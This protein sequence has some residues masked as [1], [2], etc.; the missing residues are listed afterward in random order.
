M[1]LVV[2]KKNTRTIPGEAKEPLENDKYEIHKL[3]FEFEIIPPEHWRAMKERWSYLATLQK[4]MA[5]EPDYEMPAADLREAREPIHEIA[6]R[7]L[8]KVGPL[9]DSEG[10]DIEFNDDVKA[11]ILSWPWMHG[12]I[13]DTFLAVQRGMTLTDFLKDRAEQERLEKDRLERERRKN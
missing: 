1:P 7:Y 10:N 5:D 12:P 8:R 6:G 4:R 11:Q 13:A 3:L 2:G 9:V